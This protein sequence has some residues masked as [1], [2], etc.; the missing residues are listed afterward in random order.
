MTSFQIQQPNGVNAA[1]S[2]YQYY[3]DGGLRFSH[4]VDDRFDRAFTYDH[5]ARVSEAYSGSEARD[6]INGTNSGVP[7]APF[8]QSYQYNG[9]DQVTQQYD[10]YWSASGTTTNSFVNNRLQGWSY[11][12]E[13][14]VTND[15]STNYTWD[16]VGR[17]TQSGNSPSFHTVKFDGDSNSVRTSMLF[18]SNNTEGS[19]TYYLR[20]SVLGSTIA[21]LNVNGQ[22]I[23]SYVYSGG[24]K[25][26][27]SAGGTVIWQ[28]QDPVT[29]SLSASFSSGSYGSVAERDADGVD[30][31]FNEPTQPDPEIP[32]QVFER[33]GRGSSCGIGNPNCITCYW[34]GGETDCGRVSTLAG[35]GALTIRLEDRHG[36]FRDV[37]LDVQLGQLGYYEW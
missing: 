23:E 32:E 4:S 14:Q 20:S 13:G 25:L 16:A 12:A 5:A 30:V 35:A 33:V 11:D 6:F 18:T 10:R 22:R 34:D 36:H 37:P 19:V 31:G 24:G 28:H 27:T 26:A 3:A 2:T 21:K 17:V 15:G 9:F 1:S 29:G 8:R 7:T